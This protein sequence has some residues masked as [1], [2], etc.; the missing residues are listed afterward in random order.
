MSC[1]ACTYTTRSDTKSDVTSQKR[2]DF[3][4]HAGVIRVTTNSGQSRS[5]GFKSAMH[6]GAESKV[7][8]IVGVN[9]RPDDQS[10]PKSTPPTPGECVGCRQRMCGLSSIVQS[11]RYTP[12]SMSE[13]K[14][15]RIH[16]EKW[17]QSV[18]WWIVRQKRQISEGRDS[19]WN[20]QSPRE[21]LTN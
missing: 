11:V 20:L 21:H 17:N 8:G 13:L 14:V 15:D 10:G 6:S 3:I 7:T 19:T 5:R 1:V 16:V 12:S 9:P 2:R 18:N 4:S